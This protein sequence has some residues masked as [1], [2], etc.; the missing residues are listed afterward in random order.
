ME[1]LEWNLRGL[2][3]KQDSENITVCVSTGPPKQM[4][5]A[6]EELIGEATWTD[7]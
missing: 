4:S 7:F 2:L 5:T 1:Q 3:I 6:D